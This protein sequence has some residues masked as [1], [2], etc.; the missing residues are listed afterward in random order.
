MTFSS[1]LGAV[2]TVLGLSFIWPQ[3][4]RVFRNGVEGISPRGQLQGMSGGTLW[5]VYGFAKMN[6]PLIAAN[7]ICLILATVIASVMVRHRKMPAW[8]LIATLG[9]FFA[10][11]TAMCFITP[12]IT[13]WFA[14]VI[15]ATSILPQTWYAL[16]YADLS[17]LS[18]PMY[19]LLVINCSAWLLYGFVIGDILVSAPNF[20]V[21]PCA[22][23]IGM[24]AW[25]FQRAAAAKA[26]AR[27]TATAGDDTAELATA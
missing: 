22:A 17:G 3:V 20:L 2:C 4:F 15:G 21:T 19:S 23:I 1:I 6:P 7:L 5:T 16:R 12:A 8:H 9:T 25:G 26:A 27:V 11:G 18:I 13:A 10:F 24:K 14:I